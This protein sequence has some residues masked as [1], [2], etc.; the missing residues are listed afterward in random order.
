MLGVSHLTGT[1]PLAPGRDPTNQGR[2][3]RTS[4]ARLGRSKCLFVTVY[5]S[6][7]PIL[8]NSYSKLRIPSTI[9]LWANR[10]TYLTCYDIPIYSSPHA[11]ILHHI[12]YKLLPTRRGEKTVKKERTRKRKR[13][14]TQRWLHQD[15]SLGGNTKSLHGMLFE[16]SLALQRALNQ[17]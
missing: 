5:S 9:F 3:I 6:G 16:P 14:G 4:S 1:V 2:G 13:N 12:H 7:A 15:L 17:G 10:A 11:Y 8:V